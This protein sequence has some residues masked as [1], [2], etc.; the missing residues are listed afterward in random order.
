MDLLGMSIRL[1]LD[2][3]EQAYLLQAN[4]FSIIPCSLG[5]QQ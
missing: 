1:D 4:P 2:S 3:A 5:L